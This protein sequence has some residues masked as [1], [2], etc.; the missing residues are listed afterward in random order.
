MVFRSA[1]T[2]WK[3]IRFLP[4]SLLLLNRHLIR[5]RSQ[6][7]YLFGYGRDYKSA[8][9]DFVAVS[10]SI[11]MPPRYAFGVF[12]S[13]YWAY[14]DVGQMELVREYEARSIPLDVLV[15]DMVRRERC[16]WRLSGG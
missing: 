1:F 7:L 15:T 16:V 3:L 4:F 13:R 9:R 11:A 8:L 10:G 5:H 2:L 14:S 6:D 12:Y